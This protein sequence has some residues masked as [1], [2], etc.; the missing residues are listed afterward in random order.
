VHVFAA[1][2]SRGIVLVTVLVTGTD[3]V[4]PVPVPVLNI[5]GNVGTVKFFTSTLR[6]VVTGV[7]F[8]VVG[9]A[10]VVVVVSVSVLSIK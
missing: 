5:F 4:V 2:V 3:V 7:V 8:I 9:K 10:D 6:V 1:A